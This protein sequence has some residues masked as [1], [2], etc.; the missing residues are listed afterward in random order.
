MEC[1]FYNNYDFI[2]KGCSLDF[3]WI[4]HVWCRRPAEVAIFLL[5]IINDSVYI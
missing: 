2:L 3:R 5:N 1:P 4:G